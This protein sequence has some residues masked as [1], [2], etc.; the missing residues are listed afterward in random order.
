MFVCLEEL[1]PHEECYQIRRNTS[2]V[3]VRR[4]CSP[5]IVQQLHVIVPTGGLV[6]TRN[7]RT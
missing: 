6:R 7:P 2:E 4:V 5:E 3:K 1:K